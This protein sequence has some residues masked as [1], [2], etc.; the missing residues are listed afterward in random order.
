MKFHELVGLERLMLEHN[1][2]MYP[3][4]SVVLQG[5]DHVRRWC[6]RRMHDRVMA[7]QHTIVMAVQDILKQVTM[8]IWMLPSS[9]SS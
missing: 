4:S 2:M 1:D 6:Y 8:K 5:C 3:P 9:S 7:R